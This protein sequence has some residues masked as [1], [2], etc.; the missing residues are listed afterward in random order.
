MKAITLEDIKK[1]RSI[2]QDKVQYTHLNHSRNL[3]QWI[4]TEIFLKL[5]NQQTTGSFKIRGATNKMMSLTAAEKA[6]GVVASSAGNHAQGVALAAKNAGCKAKIV[7]PIHSPLVK[8]MATQNYGAEVIL[9]G[10]IYDE[11]YKRAREIEKEEGLT[12]VHPYEDPFIIAGQ[13]TLG[14]ELIEQ[15]PDLESVLIPIGGG[16]LIAGIA[17][18]LKAIKPHVKIIGAVPENNPGMYQMFK[19]EK[20]DLTLRQPTIADG[21]SVKTPSPVMYEQYLKKWVDDVVTVSEDEIAEAIVM[22][23]ERAKAVV[24]GSGA[25]SLAAAKKSKLNLGKKSIVVLTGGNIDLNAISKVIERGLSKKGRLARLSVVVSDKPGTLNRL[26]HIL[27]EK[28]ANVLQVDHD[29]LSAGL[30]LSETRIEFLIETRSSEHIFEIVNAF[31][32]AG[33]RVI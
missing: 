30:S 33:A 24:E 17:T 6:K 10:E 12:F 9:H 22:L 8:V 21:L 27:A 28:R 16:G 15:L 11:S 26:T 4:G 29:R 31:E 1:A 19:G 7:M 23:L 14:L 32:A 5:E 2:I 25:V 18:A 3:S 20:P 13:G